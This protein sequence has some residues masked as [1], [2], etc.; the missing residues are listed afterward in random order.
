MDP[1]VHLHSDPELPLPTQRT[2][3]FQE[4]WDSRPRAQQEQSLFFSKLPAEL[5]I[6]VYESLFGGQTF[7]LRARTRWVQNSSEIR[8]LIGPGSKGSDKQYP[9][10][11]KYAR[12][13]LPNQ[14]Q[15]VLGPLL[16]CHGIYEESVDALYR[17]N[18]FV[19]S[20]E[21]YAWQSS[22]D[23]IKM[24]SLLSQRMLATI[25]VL[26]FTLSSPAK[27]LSC[28]SCSDQFE[29]VWTTLKS[30]TALKHLRI[31]LH[32]SHPTS[33]R[34][35][36]EIERIGSQLQHLKHLETITLFVPHSQAGA[37]ELIKADCVRLRWV[38]TDFNAYALYPAF[39]EVSLGKF[40][41]MGI[42][43]PESL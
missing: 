17:L 42:D 14:N 32:V 26:Q 7:V 12:L 2:A 10:L 35:K 1:D 6:R 16:S 4:A 28:K 31:I 23:T 24:S 40:H 33:T 30:F 13:A 22:L 11:R 15:G 29:Q 8:K 34:G 18:C 36:R 41:W 38:M 39:N 5:R 27:L 20:S 43:A 19:I 25:Q 21:F 9:V 37:A 3:E